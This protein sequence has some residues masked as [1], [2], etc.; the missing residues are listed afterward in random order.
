MPNTITKLKAAGAIAESLQ[1]VADYSRR[2][3]TALSDPDLSAFT[4]EEIDILLSVALELAPLTA[5][6]VSASSHDA[7]WLA[8]P[9]GGRMSVEAGSVRIDAPSSE[10]VDWARAVFAAE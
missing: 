10:I 6:D 8:I 1:P 2:E 5:M 9:P 3:F 4:V 7:L